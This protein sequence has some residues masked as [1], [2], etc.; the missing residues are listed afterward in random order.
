[1]PYS[2]NSTELVTTI[3]RPSVVLAWPRTELLIILVITLYLK[4][5]I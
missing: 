1:M 3:A 2:R 5:L 4:I